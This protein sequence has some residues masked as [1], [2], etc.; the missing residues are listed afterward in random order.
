MSASPASPLAKIAKV[1]TSLT[2]RYIA[3]YLAVLTLSV[4]MLQ[5][6]LYIY[7][8][9]TYFGGLNE[10]IVEELETLE[11]IYNGQSVV[12]VT[13]YVEDQ[14][15]T[16]AADHFYY[17]LLDREGNKVAGDL[18]AS[19]RYREFSSGWMGFDLAFLRWGQQLDVDF[20]ARR[21]TLGNGFGVMVARKYADVITQSSLVFSTLFRALVA[22]LILGLIGGFFSASSALDRI[23]NL[24][25]ELSTIIRGDRSKRLTLDEKKGYLRDLSVEMNS[26]LDQMESLMNGVRRVSD[27]IAHDLRTP[28]TRMRNQLIGLQGASHL[29]TAPDVDHLVAECDD[30]LASFN[31]LLRIS[32]LE[33]SARS[34][35]AAAEV[36]LGGLLQ[37]VYELYEPVAQEK[38]IALNFKAAPGKCKGE[39]DLLFQMFA[40]LM[41]NAVKYTP[42]RGSINVELQA[43]AGHSH[44]ITISDSGPGIAPEERENAF[45]R[46]YRVESS[47]GQQPGHGLGLSLVKAIAQYHDGSVS[48]RAN[49]PGL[50]VE[51]LLP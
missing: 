32:T 14:Y 10:A 29:D 27:N 31:A 6:A 42:E 7:F 37:D 2:F 44:R 39:A 24:N 45:R 46:F 28:L 33:S 9:F 20:L 8:S 49:N 1:L 23:E 38:N 35:S 41:D 3:K 36:D 5:G 43:G 4:F 18:D 25:L 12:G 50:T 40:N 47:R 15:R 19:P 48:L 17:L 51:V 13:A 16:P 34:S 22:T 11:I 21:A 30:L 26:M